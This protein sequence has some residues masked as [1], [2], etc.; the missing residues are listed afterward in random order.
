MEAYGEVVGV[1]PGAAGCQRVGLLHCPALSVSVSTRAA[2]RLALPLKWWLQCWSPLSSVA[3]AVT[4][5]LL[6]YS[7][8]VPYVLK[9]TSGVGG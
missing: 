9:A 5:S 8:L 4:Q 6:V 1:V 2:A 7:V 3:A